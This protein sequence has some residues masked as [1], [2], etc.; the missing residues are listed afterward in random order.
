MPSNDNPFPAD[1]DFYPMWEEAGPQLRAALK[2]AFD[3]QQGVQNLVQASMPAV[4]K[5][6]DEDPYA[7][8]QWGGPSEED[9]L[10]PSGQLCRVRNV[11]MFD[12]LSGG[13]LNNV[14][15]L[16]A[17]VKDEHI[18]NAAR[19]PGQQSE[20]P[21]VRA[22]KALAGNDEDGKNMAAFRDAIDAVVL[23]VVVKPQLWPIP[24]EGEARV[25][26][27]IYIDSV[28]TSDKIAIFNWAVTGEKSEQLKQFREG[29][30]QPVGTVEPGA[31]VSGA[32][33][34]SDR[35]S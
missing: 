7:P 4:V 35:D 5:A 30:G 23:R 28:K 10:C 20:D 19:R 15:F 21:S 33:V 1:H 11:D 27:C 17:I 9:F 6:I 29:S 22:V 14:D 32:P 26:G 24:P 13:L 8:K 16:T 2:Q 3:Q 12:L 31:N 18:P 34:G 25:D